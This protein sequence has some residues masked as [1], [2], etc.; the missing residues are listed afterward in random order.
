MAGESCSGG[1]LTCSGSGLRAGE[2]T[3]GCF[4]RAGGGLTGERGRFCSTLMGR[5]T[6]ILLFC[7]A[8]LGG[9]G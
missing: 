4:G 5:V 1:P 7:P 9:K 3:E 6:T 2:E 8:N